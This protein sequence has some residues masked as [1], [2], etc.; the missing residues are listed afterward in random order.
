[1]TLR[2]L[3]LAFVILLLP[4]G[5][6]AQVS[7][8]FGTGQADRNAPIEAESDEL[9]VN[10]SDGTA[11]FIGNVVIKQGDMKLAAP[12]V[13]VLYDDA[14]AEVVRVQAKGGVTLVSGADAAEAQVADYNVK[15]GV[16]DMQGDVLLLQDGSTLAGQKLTVDLNTGTAQVHG[17]VRTIL[18]GGE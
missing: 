3:S 2:R 12:W 9:R 16:V 11:E 14:G 8:G 5:L 7:A 17:R 18:N 15:T 1:M 6:M 4:A 10:Q 13:K